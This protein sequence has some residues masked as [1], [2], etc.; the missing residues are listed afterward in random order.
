M[1]KEEILLKIKK[2]FETFTEKATPDVIRRKYYKINRKYPELNIVENRGDTLKIYAQLEA[3][4][5]QRI[6]IILSSI[7][8]IFLITITFYYAKQTHNLNEM[9]SSQ[10][11][12]ENRPWITIDGEIKKGDTEDGIIIV[13]P[14]KN[15]GKT[16][17][18][19]NKIKLQAG[20]SWNN[21]EEEDFDSSEEVSWKI[22]PQETKTI[23]LPPFSLKKEKNTSELFIL[24]VIIE[25]SGGGIFSNETLYSDT[26]NM[27]IVNLRLQN[28]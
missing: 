16:P 2:I 1:R 11:K 17:A 5:W 22:F 20:Y 25:Y 3:I 18:N 14:L 8:M 4:K 26:G 19:I 27:I 28:E 13:L 7:L 23:L 9:T 15:L 24:R 21:L 12:T 10:F 6:Y